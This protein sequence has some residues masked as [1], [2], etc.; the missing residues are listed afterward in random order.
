MHQ[1]FLATDPERLS[2][3]SAPASTTPT[4]S[5]PPG[6]EADDRRWGRSGSVIL[7]VGCDGDAAPRSSAPSRLA[8]SLKARLAVRRRPVVTWR[9]YPRPPAPAPP[10]VPLPEVLLEEVRAGLPAGTALPPGLFEDE[11]AFMWRTIEE[12]GEP[13]PTPIMA[14]DLPPPPSPPRPARPPRMPRFLG[15]SPPLLEVPRPRV[16]VRRPSFSRRRMPPHY[17]RRC[18]TCSLPMLPSRPRPRPA[19]V[20]LTRT[21]SC[22]A[23]FARNP[24]APCTP[25]PQLTPLS[26]QDS[27]SRPWPRMDSR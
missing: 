3:A 6:E 10:A 1:G 8:A 23:L 11:C 4:T 20:K 13:P 12:D 17:R 27:L 22:P 16:L 7:E 5:T 9:P 18:L 19:F 26:S 2:L 24:A 15:Q 14:W 25:A 21:V